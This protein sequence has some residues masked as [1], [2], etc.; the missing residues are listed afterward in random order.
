MPRLRTVMDLASLT[1]VP[2]YVCRSAN[3]QGCYQKAMPDYAEHCKDEIDVGALVAFV[4]RYAS[5]VKLH[6]IGIY[7]G[8]CTDY[9]C[10]SGLV[11]AFT[12]VHPGIRL[13]IVTNGQNH[14]QIQEIIAAAKTRHNLALEFSIDAHGSVCDQ[15]RGKDGYFAESMRSIEEVAGAGLSHNIHINCRYFPEHTES[16]LQ[17]RDHVLLEY[18]IGANSISLIEVTHRDGRSHDRRAYIATLREFALEFWKG[19][20]PNNIPRAHPDY[21]AYDLTYEASFT[22]PG[23]HPDGFLYSCFD[24]GC[25]CRAGHIS[26][27]DVPAMISHLLRTSEQDPCHCDR[28]LVGSYVHEHYRFQEHP[29]AQYEWP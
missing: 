26:D 22:V 6:S 5:V 17:L 24:Y 1:V 12:R 11:A 27:P 25:G 3:C 8:E 4:Q 14:A 19:Q 20:H 9:C 7:G 28:C 18:G 16:L 15:L 2:S 23:V 29:A 10:I 13:E 21:L